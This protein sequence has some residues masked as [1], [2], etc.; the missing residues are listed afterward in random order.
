MHESQRLKEIL[1]ENSSREGTF[2]LLQAIDRGESAGFV[3]GFVAAVVDRQE[4]AAEILA[5]KGYPLKA[6]FTHE[7]LLS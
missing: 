1:L 3:V 7:S 4:G 5:D 6:L 2:T